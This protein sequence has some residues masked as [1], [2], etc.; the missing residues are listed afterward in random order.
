MP[1]LIT[2]NAVLRI[3]EIQNSTSGLALPSRCMRSMCNVKQPSTNLIQ[4]Q[5]LD[6]IRFNTKILNIP[7]TREGAEGQA[8]G[9]E[10]DRMAQALQ[11]PSVNF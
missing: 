7:E 6:F 2:K 1:F 4:K 11:K 5:P 8:P 9:W 10:V 3:L